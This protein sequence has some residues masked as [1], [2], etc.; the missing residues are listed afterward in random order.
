MLLFF[1][2][3]N[4]DKPEDTDMEATSSEVSGLKEELAETKEKLA[5]VQEELAVSEESRNKLEKYNEELLE[6]VLIRFTLN[7]L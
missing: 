5:T 1:L 7:I 6:K 4:V 2:K 3:P